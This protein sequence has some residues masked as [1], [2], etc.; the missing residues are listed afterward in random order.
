MDRVVDAIYEQETLRPLEAID[1]PEHQRV[2]ITIHGVPPE[3]PD[4]MLDTWHQVYEGLTDE[5]IRQIEALALDRRH[6][7]RQE[8]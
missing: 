4:E 3:S 2:R 1:L 5:E 7:R 8:P 6:F